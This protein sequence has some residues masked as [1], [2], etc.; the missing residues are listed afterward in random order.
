VVLFSTDGGGGG[1]SFTLT[2]RNYSSLQTVVVV[3]V[4]HLP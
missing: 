2:S 1:V 4:F 3:V